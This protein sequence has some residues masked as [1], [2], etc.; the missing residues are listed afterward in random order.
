MS[1]TA[2]GI[3]T[4]DGDNRI[5]ASFTTTDG[6]NK[7]FLTTVSPALPTFTTSKAKVKY[8]HLSQLTSTHSFSGQI[9]TLTFKLTLDNGPIIEGDVNQPGVI[10]A[11]SVTGDGVWEDS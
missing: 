11:I 7:S 6:R 8:D 2:Y 9:G 4:L 1:Q 3:F 5:N 10:P